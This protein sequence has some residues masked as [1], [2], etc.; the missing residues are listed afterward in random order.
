VIKK[1][2]VKKKHP[3]PIM[4]ANRMVTLKPKSMVYLK[5]EGQMRDLVK[6]GILEEVIEFKSIPPKVKQE[7]KQEF[8]QP[9]KFKKSEASQIKEAALEEKTE[10]E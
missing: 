6:A 8:K 9:K 7:K 1:Y 3:K 5:Y 10:Q 2:K 4:N